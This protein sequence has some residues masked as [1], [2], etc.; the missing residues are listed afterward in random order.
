MFAIRR[1]GLALVA[2]GTVFLSSQANATWSI[3]IAD[4]STGEVA[5]GTV[6]CLNNFDLRAIVPVVV[7]GKGAAACQASGDFDGIRR[8]II[9]NELMDGTDPEVILQLLAQ[10][11][12]HQSRQYG[13]ADTQARALTFTGSSANQWAGGITG[14]I[15]DMVYAIQGNILAGSCVVPAIEAA[16]LATEGDMA[17][18]LMAGMEAA[19]DTGGDGRCSCSPSQP[20]SCGCPPDDFTKSGHIGCMIVARVGDTDD[21]NC[22]SSGCADGNYFLNINVPFQQSNRPDPVNQLRD[23]FDT[24]RSALDGR[25][26]AI[27]SVVTFGDPF[28][29]ADPNAGTA[30]LIELLD[31]QGQPITA[32][33]DSI[34]VDHAPGSDGISTIGDITDL[35]GGM[36]TVELTS[37]PEVGL[38]RFRI[39]VDDGIRNVTLAPDPAIAVSNLA[40]FDVITGTH[41]SGGIVD[42]TQSDDRALRARSGFDRSLTDL[43]KLELDIHAV[44]HVPNA[45]FIDLSIE[46][47]IDEPAGRARVSLFDWNT[48]SFDAFPDF[49]ITDF[50]A[51]TSFRNIPAADYINDDGDIRLRLRHT[52]VVPIFAFT[53]ESLI[54]WVQI[55]VR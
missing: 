50:D 49:V 53:F 32:S 9:F 38:D 28:L 27:Q 37:G 33:I 47:H 39:T 8:P 20:T 16:M 51:T 24:W 44:T 54:D 30:M 5:V 29:P 6:T 25:P 7:V 2:A 45:V 4:R 13:I 48:N 22:S 41:L 10:I 35:G 12:G 18:I 46:S 1:T 55:D 11:G 31:W 34:T 17:A 19:R 14:E 42:L 43:H 3:V 23:L 21:P 52:V 40:D 26:D 15:G 36:Y